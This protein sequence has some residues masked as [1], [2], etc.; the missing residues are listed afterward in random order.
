MARTRK[1]HKPPKPPQ[2]ELMDLLSKVGYEGLD[3]SKTNQHAMAQLMSTDWDTLTAV[4]HADHLLFPDTLY[5]RKSDGKWEETKVMIRVPREKDLRAARVQARA[6][7][8]KEGIDEDR[9]ADMFRN[10]ENLCVL[11]RIIRDATDPFAPFMPDP[12]ILETKY[13]KACLQHMWEKAD[14]LNS[15]VDPAP[16]QLSQ[17]EI[18]ALILAIAKSRHLGPLVV[19]G[20]GAQTSYVVSMGDLVLN[21]LS[22]KL[23]SGSLE[24]LMREFLP[25]DDSKN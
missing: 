22:S 7:A 1:P 20:P 18:V 11:S 8:A 9:D 12:L 4:E 19:Y 3:T 13:D 6:L 17:G 21:L 23:S 25:S 15:V 2:E 5:K 24:L 14:K 10:L 16:N